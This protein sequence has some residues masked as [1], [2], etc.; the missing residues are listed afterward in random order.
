MTDLPFLHAVQCSPLHVDQQFTP[1]AVDQAAEFFVAWVWHRTFPCA[2]S[3]TQSILARLA[4]T[5]YAYTYMSMAQIMGT[6][7]ALLDKISI[8]KGQAH[9]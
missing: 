5:K 6:L 3:H 1:A 2:N 9:F 7:R 8:Y 4:R